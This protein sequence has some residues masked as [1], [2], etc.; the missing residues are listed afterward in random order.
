MA[1]NYL[2]KKMEEYERRKRMMSGA[3]KAKKPVTNPSP[4]ALHAGGKIFFGSFQCADSAANL[5]K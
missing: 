4:D 2:E 1:D 5:D 3:K